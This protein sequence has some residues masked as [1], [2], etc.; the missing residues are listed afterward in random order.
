MLVKINDLIINTDL[1]SLA[2]YA[3]GPPD[4]S[5][6]SLIIYFREN[7]ITT[8]KTFR[9]E[10]ADGLWELLCGEARDALAP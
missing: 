9:E 7:D 8:S 2:E 5:R 3:P 6:S 4:G 10:E 1:I